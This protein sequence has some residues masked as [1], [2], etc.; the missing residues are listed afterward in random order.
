MITSAHLGTG[1]ASRSCR[2][3][4]PEAVLDVRPEV[5]PAQLLNDAGVIGA[6]LLAAER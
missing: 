3:R 1:S 2:R 5:R 4:P 6:A